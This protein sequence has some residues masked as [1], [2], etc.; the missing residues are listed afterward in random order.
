MRLSTFSYTL[1]QGIKNII[2]NKK[3]SLAS[4]ATMAA[5]IFLFGLVFAVVVNFHSMVKKAEAQMSVTVFFNDET[6][7][8][9]IEEIGEI[10]KKRVEVASCEYVSGD[11]AWES[12]QKDY[13]DGM[14]EAAAGF[15]DDN[16]LA[17]SDH[18]VVHLRDVS[19][20]EA[21]VR[22]VQSVDGVRMVKQA[23]ATAETLTDFNVLFG[24][25]SAGIIIILV[26]VAVFLI[27]ITVTNG[28]YVRREEI[29]IMKLI[30]ATDFIVRAPFVVEG[31][32]IGLVG[33][34]LPLTL[35]YFL[36]TRLIN[37]IMKSFE[38]LKG[39]LEFLPPQSIFKTLLPIGLLLGVGIGF[40][41]S[42][43]TVRKHLRV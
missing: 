16:P 1:G 24:Y 6:T 23:K 31:I 26:A 36:Y 29:A 41:G 30:G 14:E 27:N 3:F 42:Y 17:N 11:E 19:M 4:I 43:S 9:R 21:L 35:L 12:F 39:I 38:V 13:F 33:A 25:L 7:D 15:A 32:L 8:E 22:Y 5:C 28:I 34:A 18:Y 2:R 37:H 20:Q 40:I 10:I